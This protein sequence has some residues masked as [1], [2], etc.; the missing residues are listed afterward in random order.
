MPNIF[1]VPRATQQLAHLT[2]KAEKSRAD[3]ASMPAS[4]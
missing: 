1:K 4:G 3:I 2:S